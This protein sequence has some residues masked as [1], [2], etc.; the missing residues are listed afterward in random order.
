MNVTSRRWILKFAYSPFHFFVQ[1]LELIFFS[2]YYLSSFIT[3]LSVQ[4]LTKFQTLHETVKLK[5]FVWYHPHKDDRN[6]RIWSCYFQ[7]IVRSYKQWDV[8]LTARSS[9]TLLE[10]YRADLRNCVRNKVVFFHS[11]DYFSLHFRAFWA[12]DVTKFQHGTFFWHVIT[13]VFHLLHP[14]DIM[15][16]SAL[17]DWRSTVW[18]PSHRWLW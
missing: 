11:T 5:Y 16:Y 14:G 17:H 13:S 9:P 7:T 12:S 10:N 2:C 18:R 3:I 15:E 6:V 8:F 4:L 1:N